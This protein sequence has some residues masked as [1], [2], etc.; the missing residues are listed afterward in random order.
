MVGFSPAPDQFSLPKIRA[1]AL[2]EDILLGEWRAVAGKQLP[3]SVVVR[4]RFE[5]AS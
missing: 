2:K 4:V 3:K 1:G 5:R